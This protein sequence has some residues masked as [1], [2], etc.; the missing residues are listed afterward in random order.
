[1]LPPHWSH[2]NPVDLIGDADAVRYANAVEILMQ[3][4]NVDALLVVYCPT[5]VVTSAD[6][7][8]GLVSALSKPG[9]A[10]K[11][12]VFACWMGEANVAD[13]RAQLVAANV[14][15]YETPERAVRAFMYLVRYRQSQDLLLQTPTSVAPSA[16][17]DG[18]RAHD[19]IGRA[20]ADRREWLDPAEVAEFLACY[21]IPFARTEAVADAKAAA[22]VAGGSM[23][24]WR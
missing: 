23:L 10:P 9:A 16:Q 7:A 1:V 12:N 6:A 8:N 21:G 11:K 5:A 22:A 20:L 3:D 15:D 2:G 19:L 17:A 24:R 18:R 14:P 13:G 4:T